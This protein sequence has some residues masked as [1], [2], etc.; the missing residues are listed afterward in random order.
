[1]FALHCIWT[2][3]GAGRVSHFDAQDLVCFSRA[4]IVLDIDLPGVTA[5]RDSR[6]ELK[7]IDGMSTL[8]R[9]CVPPKSVPDLPL[10]DFL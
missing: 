3:N 4:F 10:P 6:V 9:R 5:A 1:L 8:C 7:L 2:W